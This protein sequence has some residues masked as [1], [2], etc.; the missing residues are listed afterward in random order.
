MGITS[1]AAATAVATEPESRSVGY[2]ENAQAQIPRFY[3]TRVSR[4]QA[5]VTIAQNLLAHFWA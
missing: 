4:Q 1:S 3:K 2:A 5:A